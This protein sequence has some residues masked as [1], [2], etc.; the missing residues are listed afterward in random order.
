MTDTTETPTPDAA[1]EIL[2]QDPAAASSKRSE[3]RR[4]S[5][6]EKMD[7]L[8]KGRS[9]EIV[10]EVHLEKDQHFVTKLGNKGRNGFVIKDVETGE[11]QVVGA[12]TLQII[13]DTYG[14]VTIPPKP[15]KVQP[16]QE[17]EESVDA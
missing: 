2:N 11:T 12:T 15:A 8:Y 1:D 9:F 16:A 6:A 13:Q 17:A 7:E 4:Q 5:R 10:Q 14:G 3:A